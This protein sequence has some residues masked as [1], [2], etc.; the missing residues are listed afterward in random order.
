MKR[1][2]FISFKTYD[3]NF[4]KHLL[5]TMMKSAYE[6]MYISIYKGQISA[7][8]NEK[9]LN[10]WGYH[11]GSFLK[12]RQYIRSFQKDESVI[13]FNSLAFHY[14]KFYLFI[15]LSIPRCF[16]V[17]DIFDYFYYNERSKKELLKF[18]IFDAIYRLT[19]KRIITLSHK[20]TEIYKEA[21][22]LDNASHMT[23][24]K[25]DLTQNRI[26]I[27]GSLDNRFDFPL[28]EHIARSIPDIEIAIYGRVVE[29]N[30]GVEQKM[31]LLVAANQN[32]KYFGEY[33][34][35]KLQNILSTIDIGLVPYV[36]DSILT[37]YINPD[38][39]FHYLCYGLEV[40]STPIEAAY[41]LKK[42]IHICHS[43]ED[44]V[45]KIREIYKGKGLKNLGEFWRENNW[46]K[47][48]EELEVMFF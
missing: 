21:Y 17:Y 43:L 35:D 2:V 23:R 34:N 27:I 38:K 48:L 46:G 14:L 20:L 11:K 36:L 47:R 31:R 6:V 29:G 26:G 8:L 30:K 19:A 44:F 39:Y 45:G 16:V 15:R 7:Y 41:E 33:E 28:V 25:T 3:Q 1:I 40:I 10:Q 32:I 22:W 37:K 9:V 42:W 18:K 13:F 24:E 12:V 4:R 5:Q